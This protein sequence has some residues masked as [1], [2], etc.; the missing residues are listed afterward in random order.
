MLITMMGG[1]M[2]TSVAKEKENRTVEVL[3]VSLKP[4]TL[5]MGKLLGLAIVALFQMSVWMVGGYF[6][7]GRGEETFSFGSAAI[8]AQFAIWAIV[9]FIFGYLMYAATLGALGAIAP[10]AREGSQFSFLIS[11]P[12]FIPLILNSVFAEAPQS[13]LVIFLSLFPLTASISMVARLASG[14]V[15]L[16]Q[17]AT[18]LGGLLATTFLFLTLSARA[19]RADILLSSETLSPR[20]ILAAFQLSKKT[21][22]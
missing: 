3:L 1:L 10:S 11:L 21:E 14:A 6:A 4:K 20:R 8:P 22:T 17:I 9:F 16:W 15:P 18:S 19:Y 7:L 5:M 2:L 13:P 12:L